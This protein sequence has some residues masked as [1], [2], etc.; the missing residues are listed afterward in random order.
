LAGNLAADNKNATKFA[1]SSRVKTG[2][3][4]SMFGKDWA[5]EGSGLQMTGGSLEKKL[6]KWPPAHRIT[7]NECRGFVSRV[8]MINRDGK[9]ILRRLK[10]REEKLISSAIAG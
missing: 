4:S 3:E 9:S 6:L 5:S 1:K 8:A 2:K 10:S 7:G